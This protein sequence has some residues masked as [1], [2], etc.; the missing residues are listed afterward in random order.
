MTHSHLVN[1]MSLSGGE[2]QHTDLTTGYY[3][4]F[5]GARLENVTTG[6]TNTFI[7]WQSEADVTDTSNKVAIGSS[8]YS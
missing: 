8:W 4:T 7:G 6:N 3:S 2:E 1:K 5:I